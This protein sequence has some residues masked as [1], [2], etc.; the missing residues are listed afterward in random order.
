VQRTS[1][2]PTAQL[3]ALAEAR[4]GAVLRAADPALLAPRAFAQGALEL[5]ARAADQL[6]AELAPL[7]AAAAADAHGDAIDD[8]GGAAAALQPLRG[9]SAAA[10]A[11][12]AAVAEAPPPAAVAGAR[13]R[14]AGG[15]AVPQE[16]QEAAECCAR[17][18]ASAEG[19]EAAR[20]VKANA[21]AL[22]ARGARDHESPG[23]VR[24]AG[25][26]LLRD[27]VAALVARCVPAACA[28]AAPGGAVLLQ[29]W[30]TDAPLP[31]FLWPVL[32]PGGG[33]AGTPPGSPPPAGG[34][35]AAAPARLASPASETEATDEDEDRARAGTRLAEL[36]RDERGRLVALNAS[37]A[38][39]LDGRLSPPLDASELLAASRRRR[40]SVGSEASPFRRSQL[41]LSRGDLSGYSPLRRA[42]ESAAAGAGNSVNAS[43]TSGVW[44][45][46]RVA[47]SL[48]RLADEI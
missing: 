48:A 43:D 21:R 35:R 39:S 12:A 6:H 14:S 22:L 18:L 34:A 41:D 32:A 31:R 15:R 9:L 44:K 4:A 17:L 26:A 46:D 13:R 8:G 7:V 38:A 24:A 16:L 20:L 47:D 5:L 25:A 10:T 37:I 45:V 27:A 36:A 2:Q 3:Q 29:E 42:G 30:V 23:A 28:V 40:S 33:E 1:P 19:G 11:A